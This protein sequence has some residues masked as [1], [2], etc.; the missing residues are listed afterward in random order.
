M[1]FLEMDINHTQMEMNKA[2]LAG[3][4]GS[5]ETDDGEFATTRSC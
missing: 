1:Q 3:G 5:S 2:A 4:V